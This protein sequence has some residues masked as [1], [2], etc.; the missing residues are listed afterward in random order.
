MKCEWCGDDV[1][2]TFWT[3]KVFGTDLHTICQCC[4]DHLKAVDRDGKE[5]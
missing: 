5:K 4:Y 1:C 2:N 3:I